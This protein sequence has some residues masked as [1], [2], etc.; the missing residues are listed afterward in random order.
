MDNAP[1]VLAGRYQVGELIGRGGMAEVHIGHDN[2]L[3]RTVAIKIL[4]SDLARDPLAALEYSHHAAGIVHRDIK[5][6]QRN[7]HAHGRGEGHG[8]RHR[9]CHGAEWAVTTTQTHRI[10]SGQNDAPEQA[11]GETVDARSDLYST[12]C[13]LYEPPTGRPPFIG[14]LAISS[15]LPARARGARDAERDRSRRARGGPR[16][17]H[18]QGAGQGPHGATLSAAEFWS[19]WRTPCAAGRSRLRRSASRPPPR[20]SA[21]PPRPLILQPTPPSRRTDHDPGRRGGEPLGDQRG[22]CR[23]AG[24]QPPGDEEQPKSRKGLMW[25]LIAVGVLAL[26]AII[27]MIVINSQGEDEPTTGTVR[28]LSAGVT[29]AE[30]EQRITEA[31]S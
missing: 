2:R 28:A 11:R 3:G 20:A 23:P 4:R 17:H 7:Y 30:A 22:S 14:A 5:P 26:A 12:G 19:T 6:A 13:L 25:T 29:P 15:G 16:P 10:S 27:T 31:G 8:L 21:L 1:R 9:P 18:A 24:E